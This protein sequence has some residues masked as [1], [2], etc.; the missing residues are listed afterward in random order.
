MFLQ[1]NTKRKY[2]FSGKD[3]ISAGQGVTENPK[4]G[5]FSVGDRGVIELTASVAKETLKRYARE[6]EP[7]GKDAVMKKGAIKAKNS[8]PQRDRSKDLD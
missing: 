1:F 7:W 3:V 4:T 5:A 8:K 2:V 6:C